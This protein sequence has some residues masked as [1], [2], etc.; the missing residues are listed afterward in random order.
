VNKVILVDLPAGA[1]G[2]GAVVAGPA[3]ADPT[4]RTIAAINAAAQFT[5]DVTRDAIRFAR[6]AVYDRCPVYTKYL[7]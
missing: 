1:V 7:S 4:D 6:Q 5:Q 3:H 2:L